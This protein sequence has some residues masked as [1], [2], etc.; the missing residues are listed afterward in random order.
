MHNKEV[1]DY[2]KIGSEEYCQL[3]EYAKSRF[4][5]SNKIFKNEV[6]LLKKYEELI[7]RLTL[8]L[9][10]NLPK[11]ITDKSIRDLFADIFDF[12]YISRHLILESYASV[13]FPLLRRA[14]ESISLMQ[15]FMFLPN[16]AIIWNNGKQISNA[17][18]RKY[19][20]SHQMGTSEK[21]MKILYKFFSGAAH[22]NREYIPSRF[23]GEENQFV[24]GAI[25]VTDEKIRSNYIYNLLQLWFWFVASTSYHYKELLQFSDKKYIEDYM[26]IVNGALKLREA[27]LKTQK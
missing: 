15:Y 18:I 19:L 13:A 6:N 7:C 17:E 24:L 8:I 2:K 26:N 9:G 27:L 14:F 25:G 22:P 23:L 3:S 5:E 20:D 11:D 10:D 4:F 21:S 1:I 16:K 12:L